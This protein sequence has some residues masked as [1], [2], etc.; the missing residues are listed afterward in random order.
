MLLQKKK[1]SFNIQILLTITLYLFKI[2]Q[3]LFLTYSFTQTIKELEYRKPSLPADSP[4]CRRVC[5]IR[6][7]G[8]SS[9]RFENGPKPSAAPKSY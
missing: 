1:K 7:I 4:S 9:K 5:T 8:R 3:R 2:L 6:S